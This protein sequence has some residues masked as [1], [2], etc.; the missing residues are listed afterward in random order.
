MSRFAENNN[1][2]KKNAA[3]NHGPVNGACCVQGSNYTFR[4]EG[5]MCPELLTNTKI[6]ISHFSLRA[7]GVVCATFAP[8]ALPRSRAK[9]EF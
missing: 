3:R 8:Q 6:R 7:G 1:N 4:S 9:S 2:K 5:T